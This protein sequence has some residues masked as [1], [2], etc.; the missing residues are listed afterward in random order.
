MIYEYS[1]DNCEKIITIERS[2]YDSLPTPDCDICKQ[3]AKRIW[4][5]APVIFNA[6]GFYSTDK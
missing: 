3:P 1:C 5:A 2:I 4:N 6:K